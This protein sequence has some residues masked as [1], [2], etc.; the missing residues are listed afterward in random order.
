ML[1]LPEDTFLASSS[2][3]NNPIW[4]P[5]NRKFIFFIVLLR[6]TS[7]VQLPL[8]YKIHFTDYLHVFGVGE[9]NGAIKKA[10]YKIFLN[11][12]MAA[13][14]T[15]C[16]YISASIQDSEEIPMA[17]PVFSGSGNST[18]L[19]GKIDV[20]TGSEKFKM[21]APNRM[22]LYISFYTR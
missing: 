20:E 21:V 9:L 11:Q 18:V 16:T 8:G 10:P 15:G 22:Y 19:S 13:A 12:K 5:Q 1:G 6:K 2:V 14:K 3:S 17:N 4:R 7:A